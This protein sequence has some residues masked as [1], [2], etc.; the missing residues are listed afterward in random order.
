M[1][2]L[3]QNIG[4]LKS[5]FKGNI[6]YCQLKLTATE[7]IKIDQTYLLSILCPTPGKKLVANIFTL[8]AA[9]SLLSLL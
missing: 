5:Q 8:P 4:G 9:L 2:A 1:W 7:E 3:A 6:S